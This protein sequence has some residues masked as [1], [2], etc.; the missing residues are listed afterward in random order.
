MQHDQLLEVAIEAFETRKSLLTDILNRRNSSGVP[1]PQPPSFGHVVPEWCK[2][3]RC[4]QMPKEKERKCCKR[5]HC[6][7]LDQSFSEICLNSTIL[8]IAVNAR[9]DIRVEQ[10]NLGHRNLRHTGYRQFVMWQH[11]PLGAGNRVVIPSCCV[12]RIRT[13]FSSADNNYTGYRDH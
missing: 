7:T 13:Q 3:G 1:D 8:E 11:G 12:W 9:S 4:R 5:R 2:C 10:P 6:L